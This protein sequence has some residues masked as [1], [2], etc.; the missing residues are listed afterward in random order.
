MEI[1][2]LIL[3]LILILISGTIGYKLHGFL[4]TPTE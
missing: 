1:T 2:T 4:K 3:I